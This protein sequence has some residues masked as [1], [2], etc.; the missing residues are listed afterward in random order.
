MAFPLTYE[1]QH[2][3]APSGRVAATWG[4]VDNSIE[5]NMWDPATM[6]KRVTLTTD[7]R[8]R[9]ADIMAR[10]PVQLACDVRV[11]WRPILD[12]RPDMCAVVFLG[13]ETSPE[14]RVAN[15]ETVL[16]ENREIVHNGTAYGYIT[17]ALVDDRA[18]NFDSIDGTPDQIENHRFFEWANDGNY[19]SAGGIIRDP[20]R[21]EAIAR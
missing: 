3:V 17:H 9:V 19:V 7:I 6:E 15:L 14:V 11:V 16:W 1:Y 8:S 10:F 13:I 2:S 4:V 18:S 5:I 20:Y 21:F 12:G